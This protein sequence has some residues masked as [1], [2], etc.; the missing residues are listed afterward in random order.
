[1][2]AVLF[3]M[4]F[5]SL[6]SYEHLIAELTKEKCH[7]KHIGIGTQVTHEHNSLEH[8]FVCEFTFSHFTSSTLNSFKSSIFGNFFKNYFF[9]INEIHQFYNGISYLLRGPPIV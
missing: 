2:I 6:H 7:K 8:C 1:M 3:S 4:L 5:Q 9:Y